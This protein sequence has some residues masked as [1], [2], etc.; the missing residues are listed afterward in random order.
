M[1]LVDGYNLPMLVVPQSTSTGGANSTCISTGCVVD[2]NG[3]CPSELKVTESSGEG[4]A[5]RSACAAFGAP[6]Y[7]CTGAHSSTAT[8]GPTRYSQMFKSACPTAYS[9]AYDDAFI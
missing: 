8:C 6:E 3:A 4:V 7:C 9:Y 1:S 2:L 5:C